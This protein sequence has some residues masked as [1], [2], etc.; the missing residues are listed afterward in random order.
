MILQMHLVL[1]S[2]PTDFTIDPL[3]LSALEQMLALEMLTQIPRPC[4]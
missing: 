3:F 2:H 1:K 4:K